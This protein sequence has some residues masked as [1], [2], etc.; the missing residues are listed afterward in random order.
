MIWYSLCFIFSILIHI[1]SQLYKD[2][3]FMQEIRPWN[4]SL[5]HW[6]QI[7]KSHTFH[8]VVQRLILL[9]HQFAISVV[10]RALN[11]S[12]KHEMLNDGN[13]LTCLCAYDCV[14]SITYICNNNCLFDT[15]RWR[16]CTGIIDL[17]QFK[18]IAAPIPSYQ[19]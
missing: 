18:Y 19:T 9:S 12:H 4:A 10:G 3:F 5:M 1:L 2:I 8:I 7:Y 11:K 13:I 15:F 6:N 17:T 14:S 16:N